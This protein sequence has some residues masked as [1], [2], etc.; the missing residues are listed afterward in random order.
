MPNYRGINLMAAATNEMVEHDPQVDDDQA[1]NA[2]PRWNAAITQ[3]VTG[4]IFNTPNNGFVG[5]GTPTPGSL[6]HVRSAADNAV[7]MADR[8]NVAMAAQFVLAQGAAARWLLVDRDAGALVGTQTRRFDIFDDIADLPRL[9]IDDTGNVGIGTTTPGATLDVAGQ[10]RITGGSP[11]AGEVLTSDANGLATWERAQNL[12]GWTDD[13]T[14]VRLT[15]GS[16]RVGIGTANPAT[17]LD[18][19]GNANIDGV[20]TVDGPLN[21]VNEATINVTGV[22]IITRWTHANIVSNLNADMVDGRHAG[23]C[24]PRTRAA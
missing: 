14:V 24:A 23:D 7:V 1:N 5:I 16:D 15:T 3:L 10:V 6:L 11:A 13:G 4:S 17:T 22:N 2:V 20:L 21:V 9:S 12:S 8:D 18:V 19:N